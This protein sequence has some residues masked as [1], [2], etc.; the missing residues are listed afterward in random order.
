[1]SIFLVNIISVP[2]MILK[3]STVIK[4]MTI[5]SHKHMAINLT[6]FKDRS[7]VNLRFPFELFPPKYEVSLFLNTQFQR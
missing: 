7:K 2:K 1:M 3:P 5:Y 4:K 6:S